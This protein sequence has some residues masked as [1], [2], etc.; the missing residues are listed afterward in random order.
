LAK[1][2]ELCGGSEEAELI[3]GCLLP[4]NRARSVTVPGGDQIEVSL[5][6]KKKGFQRINVCY[7]VFGPGGVVSDFTN[8][9]Y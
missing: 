3:M 7:V 9:S 5:L 2:K 6:V 8:L 4:Q 1:I